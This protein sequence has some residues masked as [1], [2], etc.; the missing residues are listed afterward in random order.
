MLLEMLYRNLRGTHSHF[1]QAQHPRPNSERSF[2]IF[3]V[4]VIFTIVEVYRS[5]FH[6]FLTYRNVLTV[7]C[8][9]NMIWHNV[10]LG[11][12]VTVLLFINFNVR[13]ISDFSKICVISENSIHIWQVSPQQC[14]LDTCQIW[15]WY[16]I[17]KRWIYNFEK[18]PKQCDG[19]T[20]VQWTHFRYHRQF[21][22]YFTLGTP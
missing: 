5:R 11:M 20:L 10:I 14:C 19:T 21:P 6:S 13:D 12:G 3:R 18:V 22:Q 15:M 17:G 8:F 2:L 9:H 7:D 16:S 4:S 1:H